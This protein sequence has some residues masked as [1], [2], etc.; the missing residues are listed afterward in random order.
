MVELAVR[1][2]RRASR[3]RGSRSTHDGPSVTADTLERAAAPRPRAVPPA[4]RGR[5][6]QHADLAPAR[7]DPRPR[8]RSWSSSGP[9][10][11][12]NRPGPGWRFE[13]VTIPR[14]DV[15]S[16]EIRAPGRR[17]APDRRAHAAGGGGL[18]PG[19][20]PLHSPL[21]AR[22]AGGTVLDEPPP[23]DPA[24]AAPA[25]ASD[26]VARGAPRRRTPR[27]TTPGDGARQARRDR[28]RAAPVLARAH[29]GGRGARS[30]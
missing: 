17:R 11:T 29:A 3:C 30:R 26:R 27:P 20:G 18:H 25:R 2:R 8:R 6:R 10:S 23:T 4:R 14:L 16:S 12:P 13:H 5:G 15:S 22:G 9:A 28:G 19:R 24:G 1:G 7:G 21:M